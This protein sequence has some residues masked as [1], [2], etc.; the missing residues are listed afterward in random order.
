MCI[1]E[2]VRMPADRESQARRKEPIREILDSPRLQALLETARQ[3]IR[4]GEG[5]SHE[6]FWL[7]ADEE[8]PPRTGQRGRRRGSDLG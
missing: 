3:Q 2:T 1:Q 6:D 8:K 4:E 5:I 7:E